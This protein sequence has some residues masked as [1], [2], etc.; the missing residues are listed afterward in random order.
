MAGNWALVEVPLVR[1]ERM[2]RF[3]LNIII[4]WLWRE[5]FF[6][7]LYII[8]NVNRTHHMFKSAYN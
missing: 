5:F 4:P 6:F 2:H 8:K 3:R 1:S 7:I